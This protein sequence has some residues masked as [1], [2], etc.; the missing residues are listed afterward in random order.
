MLE[1]EIPLTKGYVATVD[2]EALSLIGHVSW[3]ASKAHRKVYALG[4]MNGKKVLMHRVILNPPHPLVT[5]H[6]DHNGLNNTGGNLR[7]CTRSENQRNRRPSLTGTSEY[8]GVSW[9]K[10]RRRWRA[11]IT[12][13]GTTIKLGWFLNEIHAAGA[14][15][16]AAREHHGEFARLNFPD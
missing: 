2:A 12:T 15:D 3:S 1:V 9:C 5:D 10:D 6:K 4:W 8:L 11:Q 7:A 14:Y 16:T 13:G